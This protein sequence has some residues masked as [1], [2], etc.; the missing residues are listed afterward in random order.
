MLAAKAVIVPIN[1]SAVIHRFGPPVLS[2]RISMILPK[3]TT[4]QTEIKTSANG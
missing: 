2:R 4:M 1:N 3:E